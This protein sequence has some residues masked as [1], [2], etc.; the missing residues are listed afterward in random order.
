VLTAGTG[1]SVT[2]GAGSITVTN[3][4]P[5]SGGTV[6]SVALTV[7]TGFAVSGSPI[8]TSGTLAITLS[9]ENANAVFVGPVSGAAAAPNF[10][11]L[12]LAD[13]PPDVLE[14]SLIY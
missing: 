4:S 12:T 7:P 11:A 5:S 1:I 2:N 14:A 13:L 8:T 6:T 9:N 3:T 10:R